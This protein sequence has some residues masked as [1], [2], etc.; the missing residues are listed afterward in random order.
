ML[1]RRVDSAGMAIIVTCYACYFG[2]IFLA[3]LSWISD[4]FFFLFSKYLCLTHLLSNNRWHKQV[5]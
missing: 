5:K 3:L 2:R 4:Q 1:D